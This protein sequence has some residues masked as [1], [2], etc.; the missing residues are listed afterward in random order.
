MHIPLI[1][2]LAHKMKI[3]NYLPLLS[4]FVLLPISSVQAQQPTWHQSNN[5]LDAV[6]HVKQF[7][8]DKNNPDIFF[9]T[10]DLGGL[11]KSQNTGLSWDAKG[12]EYFNGHAITDLIINP[13]KKDEIYVSTQDQGIFK[14]LDNGE[15]WQPINNGLTKKTIQ[16]LLVDP[17]NRETL[18]AVTQNQ[19][20]NDAA[21]IF[22]TD[23]DGASWTELNYSFPTNQTISPIAIN[24]LNPSN[25][26]LGLMRKRVVQST[27]LLQ[28][29]DGGKTWQSG[30]LPAA[31]I[32]F[33][34]LSYH[35]ISNLLYA[36]TSNG[37]FTASNGTTWSYVN[38]SPADIVSFLI[39]EKKPQ[40]IYVTTWYNLYK[41]TDNGASWN[42]IYTFPSYPQYHNLTQHPKNPD[43]LFLT[44]ADFL[45]SHSVDGGKTWK[46]LNWKLP[47]LTI[48]KLA[49]DL[50]DSRYLF[51]GS[52]LRGLWI[53]QDG[54]TWKQATETALQGANSIEAITVTPHVSSN[55][56]VGLH[57][58]ERRN[59]PF[60]FIYRS[61]DHGST[62]TPAKL[63]SNVPNS[64][65]GDFFVHSIVANPSNPNEMFAAAEDTFQED[66]T[67]PVFT[68]TPV[69]L[70][71]EDGGKSW[72]EF[73]RL[74]KLKDVTVEAMAYNLQNT[75]EIYA[76]GLALYRNQESIYKSTDGGK[77]WQRSATFS[78]EL[79]TTVAIAVNPVAA[80]KLYIA[81]T[82]G[83]YKSTDRGQ[84]WQLIKSS[85]R[86]NYP[87]NGFAI[88]PSNPN[89]LY[90][91]EY[92]KGV[93]VSADEGKSWLPMNEGL[94]NLHTK[95]FAVNQDSLFV[96]TEN[97]GIYQANHFSQKDSR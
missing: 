20:D 35:P 4:L 47:T 26:T 77:S 69:I 43:E 2:K 84:S 37:L 42:K 97:S 74:D 90:S 41:S 61:T 93:Y 36:G 19:D 9:I 24:P 68:V 54:E 50:T 44:G 56:T 46:S 22:K 83:I 79:G 53:M 85:D 95:S 55:V 62:W 80:E 21:S 57:W 25:L 58:N 52:L 30:Q 48:D 92:K 51:A 13:N 88:D 86:K 28:S 76:A 63:I 89:V 39:D 66:P 78:P 67:S 16:T 18:Y 70:K 10:T 75:K 11:Y 15:T 31:G 49:S 12:L 45:L 5:G 38:N 91:S 72:Q 23:N 8:I 71:S 96:G 1:E 94:M 29:V 34:Q 64:A 17:L 27:A 81:L 82:S 6:P 65:R 33:Q 3:K 40:Q 60:A 14:S 87:I 7:V 59:T 73:D 32:A